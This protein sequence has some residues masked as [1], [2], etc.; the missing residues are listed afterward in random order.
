MRLRSST[1]LVSAAMLVFVVAPSASATQRVDGV[2]PGAD[3][4]DSRAKTVAT[5]TAAQRDAIASLVGAA[6]TGTRATWDD[7]FGTPRTSST[8][9]AT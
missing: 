7:R 8:P 2:T 1:A 9:R 4:F 3:A 6:G 5:P